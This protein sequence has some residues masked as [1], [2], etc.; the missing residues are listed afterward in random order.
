MKRRKIVQDDVSSSAFCSS[1]CSCLCFCSCSWPPPLPRRHASHV[2]LRSL[3]EY[4]GP[5][6]RVLANSIVAGSRGRGTHVT[7][8]YIFSR[9]RGNYVTETVG[10]CIQER[11]KYVG[12]TLRSFVLLVCWCVYCFWRLVLWGGE[13]GAKAF[14]VGGSLIGYSPHC[15]WSMCLGEFGTWKSYVLLRLCC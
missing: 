2:S 6:R 13:S 15:F 7:E 11:G 3:P 14:C 8:A 1:S 12:E 5:E 10:I 9:R 4:W